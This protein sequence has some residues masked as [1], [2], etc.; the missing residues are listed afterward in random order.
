M[1]EHEDASVGMAGDVINFSAR[2]D[3]CLS[4]GLSAL[5]LD[6][7]VLRMSLTRVVVWLEFGSVFEHF[8]T[9]RD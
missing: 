1:N 9:H 5:N 6:K 4:P 3:E 2:Q 8:I 7:E